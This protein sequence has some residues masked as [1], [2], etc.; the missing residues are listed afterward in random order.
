MKSLVI[1][2]GIIAMTSLVGIPQ[3]DVDA[4]RYSQ[5]TVV[6][7]AR[8]LAMG[9]AFGALGADFST[10]SSNPAGI[11][12]FKKSEFTFTPAFYMGQTESNYNGTK[13]DDVQNNFNIGNVGIVLTTKVGKQNKSI[14]KYYQF[15]I[16]MNRTNNFNNRMLMEGY[17]TENSLSDIYVESADGI[18]YENIENDPY[19]YYAYDLNP[20]WNTYLIDTIPGY[21][22]KYYGAA[23]GGNI[24]QRKYVDSWG[25]MNELVLSLGA[26]IADRL[27]LGGAFG[28]PFV[29]Y[30]ERSTYSEI[31]SENVHDDFDNLSLYDDLHTKGAGFNM[32][33][34]MIVRVTNFFRLGGAIHSPTWFNN[35]TDEWYSDLSTEFDNNDY[36]SSLSPYGTYNYELHTPWRAMGGVSFVL[37]RFALISAD[38]EYVDYSQAKLRGSQYDFYEENDAITNK[39]TESHNIRLGTEIRFG[40]FAIR[41]G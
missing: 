7:T 3:S 18:Y 37:W 9:G 23:P 6:G 22:N 40:H 4:L 19:G 24:F 38:Y 21:E 20:A 26:N 12:L 39:Y 16:G 14:L 27:Y 28:F 30:F 10:L 13:S 29:R 25:S 32:K 1:T 35:M 17:N 31:D 8:Y 11:G 15:A 41:G 33:F 2:I 34:G 36:Y 5:T